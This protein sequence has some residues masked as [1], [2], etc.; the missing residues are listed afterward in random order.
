M[1]GEKRKN[2]RLNVTERVSSKDFPVIRGV[3]V[4]QGG[5]KVILG[6]KLNTGDVINVE[7]HIPGNSNKFVAEAEVIWQ[8]KIDRGYNTGFT[9]KKISI[10]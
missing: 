8:E 5:I 4:S 6:N 3:D 9:F 10:K 1:P 2:E 7:F